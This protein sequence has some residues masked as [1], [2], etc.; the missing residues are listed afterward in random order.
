M[1]HFLQ[2][3]FTYQVANTISDHLTY[4]E[5]LLGLGTIEVSF[6]INKQI[7]KSGMSEYLCF[8]DDTEQEKK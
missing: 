3:L 1:Y 5:V 7:E 8:R 4:E 2:M 6:L